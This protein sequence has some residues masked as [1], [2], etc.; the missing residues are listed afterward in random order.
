MAKIW[1]KNEIVQD[2]FKTCDRVE[3]KFQ[4]FFIW[5]RSTSSYA[6]PFKCAG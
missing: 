2:V 1:T 5:K 6:Q 4:F 3:I